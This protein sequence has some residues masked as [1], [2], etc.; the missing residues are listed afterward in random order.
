MEKWKVSY[1]DSVA[2]TSEYGEW[3]PAEVAQELYDALE[4]L[5]DA[6]S[7]DTYAIKELDDAVKA[8]SKADGED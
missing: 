6:C 1:D 8:L 5:L 4:N 7:H 2:R 3:V